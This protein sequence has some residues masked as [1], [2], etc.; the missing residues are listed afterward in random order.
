MLALTLRSSLAV[1]LTLWA[2]AVLIKRAARTQG[3]ISQVCLALGILVVPLMGLSASVFDGRP[4]GALELGDQPLDPEQWWVLTLAQQGAEP[5]MVNMLR[6][7]LVI[8]LLYLA[9]TMAVGAGSAVYARS[10]KTAFQAIHKALIK[11]P[12]VVV[13]GLLLLKIDLGTIVLGT[14]VA[15]VAIG[16]VLKETLENIFTGI[17]LEL[18]G[19]VRLND[20]IRLGDSGAAGQVIEKTWRATK[21]R[22]LQDVAITIPNRLLGGERIVNFN[23]PKKPHAR[24][25]KVGASYNDP[26]V[27]VKEILRTIL[28]RDQDV[29]NSPPP[30]VRTKAYDDFAIVY[31]LKFWIDDY[32]AHN[33]IEERVMTHIWYAFKFYGVEIP[34]PIRT[35]HHKEHPERLAESDAMDEAE[36]T[37][38]RFLSGVSCFTGLTRQETGFLA[39]NAFGRRYVEGEHVITRGEVGDALY[40]VE[41]GEVVVHLPNGEQRVVPQGAY[42]G[43]MGLLGTGRRSADVVGGQGGAQVLRL[44]RHCMDV[45]FRAR[46]DLKE[47]ITKVRDQRREEL[48]EVPFEV[49]ETRGPLGQ[50]ILHGLKDFLRPW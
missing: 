34:F 39:Q 50:R 30:V 24:F 46:P 10:R 36:R 4:L 40:V 6:A 16:F 32:A 41:V 25:L 28:I 7:G 37:R 49:V 31:E 43:E 19:S 20:W 29:L 47:S 12:V 11:W 35:V 26:P 33:T 18:E 27:K 22:T 38:Q 17:S 9:I 48:P 3:E 44:D 15:V 45:I 21:I 2:M 23:R 13:G 42:F 5:V 8:S 1:L 14:S